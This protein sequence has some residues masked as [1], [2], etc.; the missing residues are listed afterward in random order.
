ME[1]V[2]QMM[3][4]GRL[5]CAC[6]SSPYLPW[7]LLRWQHR[8]WCLWLWPV[9]VWKRHGGF[10]IDFC[11]GVGLVEHSQAF[12]L[13]CW[14]ATFLQCNLESARVLNAF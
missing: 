3:E 9:Q 10:L 5:G 14:Q 12:C 4:H 8:A 11:D 6:G 7:T 1:F 13:V 2:D